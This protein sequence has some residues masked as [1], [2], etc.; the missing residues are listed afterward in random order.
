MS[1]INDLWETFDAAKNNF[2]AQTK[3]RGEAS[4]KD[5]HRILDNSQPLSASISSAGVLAVVRVLMRCLF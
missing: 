3:I 4:Q 1:K 2:L 5:G